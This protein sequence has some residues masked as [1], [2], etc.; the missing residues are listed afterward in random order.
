MLSLPGKSSSE[1]PE[2]HS[3]DK[4]KDQQLGFR[5]MQL[6]LQQIPFLVQRH[7]MLRKS[8]EIL[9]CAE[10]VNQQI[11]ALKEI[12]ED[13]KKHSTRGL[14]QASSRMKRTMK[15][16]KWDEDSSSADENKKEIPKSVPEMSILGLP[17]QAQ[18]NHFAVTHQKILEEVQTSAKRTRHNRA[19]PRNMHDT[20]SESNAT[21]LHTSKPVELNISEQNTL[22]S[23]LVD[24]GVVTDPSLQSIASDPA[25]DLF[26]QEQNM[27]HM[28]FLTLQKNMQLIPPTKEQQ[29]RIEKELERGL[30]LDQEAIGLHEA[31]SC[32]NSHAAWRMLQAGEAVN[33]V[34]Q[35]GRT[36]LHLA[37]SGGHSV[38]ATMLVTEFSANPICTDAAGCTPLH[39]AVQHGHF[40]AAELLLSAARKFNITNELNCPN[41]TGSTPL[42]IAAELGKTDILRLL[43]RF[44]RV[45]DHAVQDK[46]GKTPSDIAHS[47]VENILKNE[48]KK[49]GRSNLM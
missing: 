41:K 40:S 39:Y 3:V 7:K 12:D 36:P 24:R 34:D 18:Y 27:E 32:G 13:I 19:V 26:N 2:C 35:Q 17:I 38:L 30:G 28:Y 6:R 44:G 16:V 11:N 25:A 45:V 37:V 21:F 1:V 29:D 33:S 31:C 15:A 5:G 4:D 20:I 9:E 43:L 22:D 14:R 10:F 23:V 49:I 8:I 46:Q 47:F 48:I 42:H